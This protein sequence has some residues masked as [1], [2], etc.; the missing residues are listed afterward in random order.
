[1]KQTISPDREKLRT[2]QQITFDVF[3]GKISDNDALGKIRGL[4]KNG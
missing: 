3:S 4:V 2:I 1:M